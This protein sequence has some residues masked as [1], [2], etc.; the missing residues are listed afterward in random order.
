MPSKTIDVPRDVLCKRLKLP[1]DASVEQVNA[2]LA[3]VPKP[4]RKSRSTGKAHD[5]AQRRFYRDHYPEL[6]QEG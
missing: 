5:A 2:A 3:Q 6:A 4:K 1:A